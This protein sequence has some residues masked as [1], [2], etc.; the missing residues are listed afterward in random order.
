MSGKRLQLERLHFIVCASTNVQFVLLGSPHATVFRTL[1][2]LDGILAVVD[3]GAVPSG[4][5]IL[6][7]GGT[8][9]LGVLVAQ[10]LSTSSPAATLV[11]LS[12]SG[13]CDFAANPGL[14][15]LVAGRSRVLVLRGDVGSAAEIAAAVQR[16][17]G[18]C[19]G[20]RAVLHAGAPPSRLPAAF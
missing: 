10:W 18:I 9:A 13:H 4:G 7:T 12:R 20:L 8:G 3:T 14:Q 6:I 15:A 16:C 1:T 5:C 17:H 19:G 2:I 11:L